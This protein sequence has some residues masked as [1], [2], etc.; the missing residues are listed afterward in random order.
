MTHSP[1]LRLPGELRNK[2]FALATGCY[3]IVVPHPY[4]PLEPDTKPNCGLFTAGKIGSSGKP[5][6]RN[7]YVGAPLSWIFT[8]SFVCR[9]TYNET[10]LL[11][12]RLNPLYFDA[13]SDQKYFSDKLNTNQRRAI[14]AISIN[15][16]DFCWPSDVARLRGETYVNPMRQM[17]P[18]LGKI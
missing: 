12:Y 14:T 7:P 10:S 9:Q 6:E 3:S 13:L 11:Q 1:L 17:L 18:G 5:Y 8:V 2:I 15:Y 4:R 16:G